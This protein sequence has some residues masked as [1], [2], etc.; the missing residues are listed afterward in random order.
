MA[1]SAHPRASRARLSVAGKYK[2]LLVVALAVIT[3]DQATK[4][5][6]V[7]HLTRAFEA[8]GR[9]S[10]VERLAGFYSLENLDND[11]YEPGKADLRN[12]T[13]PVV[14][15]YWN[16]KYVEN[17]GAAWGLLAGLDQ[18]WRLPFFYL[19]PLLAIGF[20]ALFYRRVQADQ[21][22]LSLALSLVFAGAIGNY[23]DRLARG[24]VID[25]IDWH[26]RGRPDMH[27]PTFNIADAAIS[28]GV[29]L[30]LLESFVARRREA[31]AAVGAGEAA[32][33]PPQRG[34][35]ANEMAPR[36]RESEPN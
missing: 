23:L 5:L 16:H 3:A 10:F 18:K 28:V 12:G 7:A 19:V 8:S 35:H 32:G 33:E 36:P 21:K 1:G 34:E 6:A 29:V 17:P 14:A 27:W 25:F 11:P 24:Y 2:V 22:L 4:Y 13:H 30:M 20:I 9:T 26:W 15:G 31:P